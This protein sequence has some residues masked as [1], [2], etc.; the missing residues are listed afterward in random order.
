MKGGDIMFEVVLIIKDD[1]HVISKF[2]ELE[3]AKAEAEKLRKTPEA[4]KGSIAVIRRIS[5]K[6]IRIYD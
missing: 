2:D 1:I 6:S 4:L 3:K 5:G